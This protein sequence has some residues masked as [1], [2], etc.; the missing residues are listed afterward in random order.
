VAF[1][2][3][4]PAT[5]AQ[6]GTR[7]KIRVARLSALAATGLVAAKAVVGWQ[8]G[9]LAILSEA[10]HSGVDLI[11]SVLTLFAVRVADRPA[12]REHH[13]GHGK[14][15]NLSALVQ[16]GFLLLTCLWIIYEAIERLRGKPAEIEPGWIAFAVMIVSIVVDRS[17]SRAL[18]RVAAAT[19]S[20]ALEADALNF[21]TDIWSSLTVLVGLSAV[22]L[23]RR[24][25]IPALFLADAVAGML[26]AGLVL[27]VGGRLGKRAVDALLDRAPLETAERVRA[28]IGSVPAVER[29]V[30]LRV[31]TAGAHVF[32]DAAISIG[33]GA[34]FENAHEV[35]SE[36]EERI[37]EVVPEARSLIH[38]EPVKPADES[39]G[40]AIRL[41]VSRHAAGAHDILIYDVGGERC[42]DLHL[43]LPGEMPLVDAHAVTE[44][45]ESDLRRELPQVKRI[46]THADPVRAVRRSD[47]E[48]E[49]DLD[50]LSA[51][52]AAL[53]SGIP[54]IRECRGVSLK[55][56]RGRLWIFCSCVMDRH[57]TL[58][59]AHEL[60]LELGRRARREIPGVERCTVH[61]EPGRAAGAQRSGNTRG[62]AA[63][64]TEERRHA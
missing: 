30:S 15:E 14:V 7:E 50:R 26:V 64:R 27:V 5:D 57:L 11:A 44:R 39:L 4:I 59:E 29:L 46:H 58:R 22:W 6:R 52:L 17:R 36:V 34:S 28:A 55:K 24:W 18:A 60:G 12:D 37:R 56:I 33:R 62:A 41:V 49:E 13:Y 1:R 10:A 54:G 20:Q 35:A 31:R 2:E 48:A 32:V 61:A 47:P 9:S 53:A 38:A 42:V 63:E 51:A 25:E 3:A 8:T 21:R 19:G 23:G 40:D 45:I 43:E 16:T